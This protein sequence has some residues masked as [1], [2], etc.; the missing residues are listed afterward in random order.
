MICIWYLH[1]LVSFPVDLKK[2]AGYI[3]YKKKVVRL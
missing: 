3:A 2:R 1:V